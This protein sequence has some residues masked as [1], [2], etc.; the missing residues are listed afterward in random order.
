MVKVKAAEAAV[1]ISHILCY[2]PKTMYPPFPIMQFNR[3]SLLDPLCLV[4]AHVFQTVDPRVW[5]RLSITNLYTPSQ[6][7]DHPDDITLTSSGLFSQ[8]CVQTERKPKFCLKSFAWIRVMGHLCSVCLYSPN[9]HCADGTNV[10]WK[11]TTDA[12]PLCVG[13]S[14]WLNS[15]LSRDSLFLLL[16]STF[17]F[18]L[19]SV[20]L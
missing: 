15:D 3:I 10:T 4:N 5:W 18:P 14:L 20:C 2:T 13:L 11:V 6:S 1:T 7:W 12:P 19:N 17:L 9:S 8:K 16:P